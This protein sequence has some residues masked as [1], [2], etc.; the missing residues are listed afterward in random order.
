MKRPLL[1]LL[2]MLPDFTKGESGSG[3]CTLDGTRILSTTGYANWGLRLRY[4]VIR[5]FPPGYTP[6][7]IDE[8]T[9]VR[10]DYD[11]PPAVRL[12][13]GS[14][15]PVDTDGAVYVFDGETLHSFKVTLTE[16]GMDLPVINE[17]STIGSIL[18]DF[19]AFER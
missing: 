2:H 9:R 5:S 19:R 15:A 11:N 6:S 4:A 3:V 18:E 16:N 12:A 13:D 7:E 8:D 14:Y 1:R 17:R 10:E